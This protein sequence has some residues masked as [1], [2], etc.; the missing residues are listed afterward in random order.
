MRRKDAALS[1]DVA[2]DAAGSSVRITA[3]GELDSGSAQEL[4]D[5]FTGAIAQAVDVTLD[6]S[7]VQFVD[8]AGLR[9]LILIEQEARA[10]EIS[11]TTLPPPEPVTQQLEIAGVAERVNLVRDG[12]VPP[13]ESDFLE[14]I[15][16][17]LP[18]DDQAPR[19]GRVAV[20]EA[21][22]ETLEESELATVVLMTS[23]LVSNAVIHRDPGDRSVIGLRILRF[24]DAI[25]V[26]VDDAGVGFDPA[27]NMVPAGAL[28][29]LEEGGR[30]LFVVDRCA[31]RWGTR[32]LHSDQG[33]RF[34]VWFEL[35]SA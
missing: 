33:A 10:R 15:E 3:R 23:E 1:L 19:R 27:L 32:R 31:T 22:G 34:A 17:D 16:L 13:R 29:A 6:L 26:E 4:V 24:P 18:P 5:A 8:S 25:R 9:A 28:P 20:R 35:E 30:G 14:R 7:G 21:L 2:P 11:L 12:Q